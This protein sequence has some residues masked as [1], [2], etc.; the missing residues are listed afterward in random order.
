MKEFSEQLD[1]GNELAES[2]P[3][4]YVFYFRNDDGVITASEPVSVMAGEDPL[5]KF[6]E[7]TGRKY[8]EEGDGF[9]KINNSNTK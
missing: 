1:F 8:G 6:T 5:K 2:L 7:I 3:G 9:L 4:D